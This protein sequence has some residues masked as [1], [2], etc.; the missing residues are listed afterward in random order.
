MS[1]IESL[2]KTAG[3]ATD[4]CGLPVTVTEYDKPFRSTTHQPDT[5]FMLTLGNPGIGCTEIGPNTTRDARN[6][7]IGFAYGVFAKTYQTPTKATA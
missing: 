7:I 3:W 5:W 1:N 4:Y 6:M 2:R